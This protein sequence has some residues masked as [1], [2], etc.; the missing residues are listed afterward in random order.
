MVV[1]LLIFGLLK[2]YLAFSARVAVS[3]ADCH[4]LVQVLL[5][6]KGSTPRLEEILRSVLTQTYTNFMVSF[7]IEKE[8]DDCHPLLKRLCDE[9]TGNE[10]LVS[11]PTALCGQKNHS[12][13]FGADHLRPETRIVVTCDSSSLARPDWLKSLTRPIREGKGLCVT[14]FRTFNPSCGSLAGV[15]QAI[16]GSL[17]SL[18]IAIEP[19]PWGGSTAI[20]RDTF[21]RLDIRSHWLKTVVDDLVMGNVLGSN[22]LQVIFAPDSIME[23][24]LNRQTFQG[25]LSFLHRQILFPKFTNPGVWLSSMVWQFLMTASCIFSFAI[26]A[27]NLCSFAFGLE[28]LV[29]LLYLLTLVGA[30]VVLNQ[31][32]PHGVPVSLWLL[33]MFPLLLTTTYVYL[34]SVFVDY[35]DW[36]GKRYH[37]GRDGIVKSYED[38]S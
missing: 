7:I 5:P 38:L 2:L 34:R 35:I 24:P 10:I 19:K 25:F 16:Y 31:I 20:E 23:S 18:L 1:F 29:A 3:A 36:S 13:A 30:F 9:F 11:G 21:D 32:N 28:T 27:S 4:S 15:C 17:V 8:D 33:A 37:C 6:I 12:L 14:T 22:G 26:L